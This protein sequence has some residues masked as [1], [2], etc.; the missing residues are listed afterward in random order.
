MGKVAAATNDI[1]PARDIVDELV[2]TAEKSLN[3]RDKSNCQIQ[4]VKP[5]HAYLSKAVTSGF[6][7]TYPTSYHYCCAAAE[8]SAGHCRPRLHPTHR[9][10]P[11]T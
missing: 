11:T 10:F 9:N 7:V 8:F 6:I 2:S 4:V 5:S 3:H 1:K